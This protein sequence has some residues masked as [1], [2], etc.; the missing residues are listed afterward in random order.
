MRA[1]KFVATGGFLTTW[2]NAMFGK[3]SVTI[4]AAPQTTSSA[5]LDRNARESRM[6]LYGNDQ[7]MLRR[8]TLALSTSR[9]RRLSSGVP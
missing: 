3:A 6:C 8:P 2:A 4:A 1:W 9:A 7:T 5:R